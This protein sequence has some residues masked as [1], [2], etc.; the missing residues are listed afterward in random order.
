MMQKE[1]EER[2]GM[3]V[4]P[5]E[6]EKIEKLYMSS[7]NIDKDT[8]CKEYKKIASSEIVKEL[9]RSLRITE[10]KLTQKTMM[11]EAAE[12]RES[13]LGDFLLEQAQKS[14]NPALREKAI[15]L[16]GAKEY[17]LR[18]LKTES[19]LWDDDRAILIE[20]LNNIPEY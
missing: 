16:I 15:E 5:A 4:T 1:F 20:T 19:P 13:D 10:G 18:K 14:G 9:Q 6:Y 2:T 12:K 3:Q 8:F 17:I 11:L 7:G